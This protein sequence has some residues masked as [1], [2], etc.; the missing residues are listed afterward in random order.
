MIILYIFN[1][2]LEYLH[3]KRKSY[4][5]FFTV[6]FII[7]PEMILSSSTRESST[8]VPLGPKNVRKKPFDITLGED[9]TTSL[10]DVN[11]IPE[12]FVAVI[13][14][15]ELP[16]GLELS[17]ISPG[18]LKSSRL[19]DVAFIEFR[20]FLLRF[21]LVLSTGFMAT[22]WLGCDVARRVIVFESTSSIPCTGTIIS[23]ETRRGIKNVNHQ[24]LKHSLISALTLPDGE[25]E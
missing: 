6:P 1:I 10:R 25:P 15:D 18:Y 13:E 23:P 16:S 20:I 5:K 2:V 14:L 22:N 9:L 19:E 8:S 17:P 12:V 4:R 7:S 3:E 24:F 11:S 21:T